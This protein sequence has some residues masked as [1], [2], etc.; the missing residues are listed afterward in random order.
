MS[1]TSILDELDD[2]N[3]DP[4]QGKTVTLSRSQIRNLE[5]QAKESVAL[6]AEIEAL[7]KVNLF[8]EVGIKS[9]DPKQ[10]YFVLGYDGEMNADAIRKAATEAGYLEA[11]GPTEEQD[12]QAAATGRIAAASTGA[13]PKAA[14]DAVS[15]KAEME[16]ALASGGKDAVLAVARKYGAHPTD[17]FQ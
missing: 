7:K 13:A 11:P 6:K 2:D 16:A 10:K 14:V 1:S 9:D 17:D 4:D 3:Q 8:A 5:K 12:A 15:M